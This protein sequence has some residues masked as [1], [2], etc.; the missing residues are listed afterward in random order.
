MNVEFSPAPYFELEEEFSLQQKITELINKKLI[1]SA[2]DV[3]EGGLFVTF[4]KVVLIVNL[5]LHVE[6][7]DDLREDAYLFG[8]GQSRV[9]VSVK[10]D[11]IENLK[12]L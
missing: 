9:V 4:V 3:S 12:M 2:H 10:A 6:T 11:H 8:E 1:Q 7:K 5:D